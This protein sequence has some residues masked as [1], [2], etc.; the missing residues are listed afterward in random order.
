[1][2]PQPP[3]LGRS[4][5]AEM[6]SA[7]LN[8]NDDSFGGS[9]RVDIGA[10]GSVTG[11]IRDAVCLIGSIHRGASFSLNVSQLNFHGM[12]RLQSP[13]LPTR[14]SSHSSPPAVA[15]PPLSP[16]L[17]PAENQV[18][19]GVSCMHMHMYSMHMCTPPQAIA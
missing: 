3:S 12:V 14:A 1:M 2:E 19:G 4:T 10:A 13:P 11:G 6:A 5:S 7:D 15:S 8:P 9:S 17:A 16:S 18:W